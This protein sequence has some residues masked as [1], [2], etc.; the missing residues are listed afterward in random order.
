MKTIQSIFALLLAVIFGS[1]HANGS[2]RSRNTD[3]EPIDLALYVLHSVQ[4]MNESG[5]YNEGLTLHSILWT[6]KIR[7][8]FHDNTIMEVEFASPYFHSG[9][10][11]E[12]FNVVVMEYFAE[13][14]INKEQNQFSSKTNDDHKSSRR[15]RGFAIDRFPKLKE[16]EIKKTRISKIARQMTKNERI[17][18]E[19]LR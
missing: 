6:E 7:G 13:E 12:S 16:D 14:S 5:I 4:D 2:R 9:S 8:R 10:E 3:T 1:R 17:R 18:M 11:T 15:R 19:S